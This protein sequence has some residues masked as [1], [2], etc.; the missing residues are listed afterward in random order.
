M[1]FLYSLGVLSY[2]QQILTNFVHFYFL[3]IKLSRI[4]PCEK[5]NNIPGGHAWRHVFMVFR[6]LE[7]MAIY[8]VK[9]AC[10]NDILA[11]VYLQTDTCCLRRSIFADNLHYIVGPVHIICTSSSA[12][13]ILT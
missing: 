11:S 10:G 9:Q 1:Y 6:K 3:F 13:T 2:F 8:L 4:D 5:H 7:T 12:N